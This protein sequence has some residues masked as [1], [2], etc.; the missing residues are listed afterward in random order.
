LYVEEATGINVTFII[1]QK[2]KAGTKILN[3]VFT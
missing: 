2:R 1:T 3:M